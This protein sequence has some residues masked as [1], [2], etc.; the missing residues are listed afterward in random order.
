MG[1]FRALIGLQGLRFETMDSTRST[2]N[3]SP[4]VARTVVREATETRQPVRSPRPSTPPAQTA[5]P[6]P[7]QAP[8][9]K[10]AAKPTGYGLPCSKCRSYYPATLSACPIC[11]STERV[12]TKTPSVQSEAPK[13]AVA[14]GTLNQERERFLKEYKA[15]L[16]AAHA[17][18]NPSG[19]QRCS[20][21]EEDQHAHEAATVCGACYQRLEERVDLAEAA[22]HMDLKEATQI[23][24]EAVWADT[25][26]SNKTYQ[27]AAQA[28]LNELRKRAGINL[29]MGHLQ[30]LPH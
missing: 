25:S 5:A 29:V 18:I 30:S 15:K 14:E 13:S 22:L 27:N 11:R 12:S 2:S 3:P 20:R 23:I 21:S 10:V 24:Y 16:Y 17:Q 9:Q 4:V 26:D 7:G 1:P 8:A 6:A 19:Q 28:I